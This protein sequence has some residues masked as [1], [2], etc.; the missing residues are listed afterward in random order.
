MRETIDTALAIGA[1]TVIIMMIAGMAWILA[2][3]ALW[4][5]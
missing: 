5:W 4:L 3:A 2:R 1:A